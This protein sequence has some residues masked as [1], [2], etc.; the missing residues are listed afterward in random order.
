[1]A[2]IRYDVAWREGKLLAF[3]TPGLCRMIED[4]YRESE[5]E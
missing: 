1:M 4:S 2:V 3:L 5:E